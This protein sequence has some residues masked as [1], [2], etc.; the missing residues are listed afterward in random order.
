MITMLGIGRGY[1]N[2]GVE[3]LRDRWG[4]WAVGHKGDGEEGKGRDRWCFFLCFIVLGEK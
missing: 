2:G 1:G 4:M 3:G